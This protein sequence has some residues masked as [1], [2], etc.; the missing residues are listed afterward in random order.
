MA[1]SRL[2]S[3]FP[4][5]ISGVNQND[6]LVLTHSV[7]GAA[8]ISMGAVGPYWWSR[9]GTLD[10][11]PALLEIALNIL[12]APVTTTVK[13][14]GVDVV[15]A[16]RPAGAIQIVVSSGTF[17]LDVFSD[18]LFV[19][20]PRILGFYDKGSDWA[21]TG[22]TLW[23]P[24]VHRYGWYPRQMHVKDLI[25][26]EAAVLSAVTPS[27]YLDGVIDLGESEIPQYTF[28]LVLGAL[29]R[30]K[31]AADP[32]RAAAAVIAAG[33]LNCAWERFALDA[34]RGAL[35]WRAYKD[36]TVDTSSSYEGPYR[37]Q[38]PKPLKSPTELATTAGEKWRIEFVGFEAK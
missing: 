27:G 22:Q 13:T 12:W 23:S 11:F 31:A 18:P 36:A 10:N 9:I 2:I 29:S 7:H 21:S 26:Q 5:I 37:M 33:D 14:N 34:T 25:A 24:W 3:G 19:M 15:D 32:A 1:N 38:V 16:A 35:R 17:T 6:T 30:I 28:D 4:L 8:V 20:D